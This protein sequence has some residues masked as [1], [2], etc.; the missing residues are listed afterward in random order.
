MSDQTMSVYDKIRAGLYNRKLPYN[1][2]ETELIKIDPENMTG[3]QVRE[4]KEAN[5]RKKVEYRLAYSKNSGELASQFRKD[6]EEDCGTTGH[7]K[8]DM[9]FNKAYD[10]GH[11]GGFE[12]VTNAYYD[13]VDLIK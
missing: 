8:A 2:P 1:P 9:L 6:L 7:P 10:R 5:D 4:A 11:S 13:M 12:E 3:K